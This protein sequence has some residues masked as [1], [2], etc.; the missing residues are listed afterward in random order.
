MK[1]ATTLI[2]ACAGLV[3]CADADVE[4]GFRVDPAIDASARGI[5]AE[6][7][8]DGCTGTVAPIAVYRFARDASEPYATPTLPE[9]RYFFVVTALDA[10]CRPVGSGC[11]EV[12]L[13]ATE[14]IE[15]PVEAR[16]AAAPVLCEP[17]ATCTD[18]VC[19]AGDAGS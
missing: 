3:A 8:S 1:R 16:T 19:V 14:R 17:G 6:V 15:V 9:G 2:V 7:R 18:G 13:P 5:A 4:W 11:V 12:E 10:E